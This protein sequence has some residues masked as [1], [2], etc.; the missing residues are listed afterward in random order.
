MQYNSKI[1]PGDYV[2]GFVD[3]EG[4]FYLNYRKETKRNRKGSPSYYRWTPYFAITIR[5]DDIEILKKIKNTLKCG[6]IYKLKRSP[7]QSS[8]QA[9]YGVQNI[10]DIFEKIVPFFNQYHLRAKKKNDFKLW[11]RAVEILYKHKHHSPKQLFSRRPHSLENKKI[12]TS[13]RAKMRQYKSKMNRDYMHHQLKN[14][15]K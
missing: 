12:L 10:D 14:L 1:L 11:S 4:C 7:K 5:E 15:K 13:L 2:A 3:G 9:W 6:K 8:A